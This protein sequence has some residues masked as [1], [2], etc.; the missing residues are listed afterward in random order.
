MLSVQDQVA[1]AVDQTT[2]CEF[3]RLQEIAHTAFAAMESNQWMR[4]M[5][6]GT[7]GATRYG[8]TACCRKGKHCRA[9][10]KVKI[11]LFAIEVHYFNPGIYAVPW[12]CKSLALFLKHRV[13]V[14]PRRPTHI[15]V[16]SYEHFLFDEITLRR[17]FQQGLINYPLNHVHSPVA[18]LVIPVHFS[19]KV[20]TKNDP[21]SADVINSVTVHT[22]L[23]MNPASR[24]N[25]TGPSEAL[26]QP[27]AHLRPA[28]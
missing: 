2:V 14:F 17:P 19:G 1:Y 15:Y 16:A 26:Q 25:L 5:V 8:S 20:L 4:F 18:V 21:H 13:N 27:A 24:A 9:Y 11:G 10:A 12:L 3:S 6:P 22:L 23:D 7:T 28:G